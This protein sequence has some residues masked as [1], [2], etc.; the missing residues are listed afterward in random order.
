MPR[1]KKPASGYLQAKEGFG[2]MFNGDQTHVAAGQLVAA[3]DP[4]VKGREELFVPWTG[5]RRFGPPAEQEAPVEQATA[6]PGEKR[7]K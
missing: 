4:I 7:N 5:P 2:T 3:D 6:A 1:T